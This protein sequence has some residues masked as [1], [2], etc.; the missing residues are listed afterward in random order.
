M[1]SNDSNETSVRTA[2]E[3]CSTEMMRDLRVICPSANL[4]VVAWDYAWDDP[5]CTGTTSLFTNGGHVNGV[6]IGTSI[7]KT[8]HDLKTSRHDVAGGKHQFTIVIELN[9]GVPHTGYDFWTSILLHEFYVHARVLAQVAQAIHNNG[10][11]ACL[12]PLGD[13]TG[14][15]HVWASLLEPVTFA[16][17]ADASHA[18]YAKTFLYP[19]PPKSS[20]KQFWTREFERARASEVAAF[21]R[22]TAH[23]CDSDGLQ[24]AV[25]L[26]ATKYRNAKTALPITPSFDN[27]MHNRIFGPN[28][29]PPS[30][31][32]ASK[33]KTNSPT[34]VMDT[35]S[36]SSRP[37]T[38]DAVRI[39]PKAHVPTFRSRA[40]D[41]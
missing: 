29:R 17:L 11:L 4:E 19:A 22:Q 30:P 5:H 35:L 12:T 36:L 20:G 6:E 15:R 33:R 23:G 37:P 28:E 27:F 39:K 1:A 34:T 26:N 40:H 21:V 13:E 9:L 18:W 41:A 3:C 38:P 32:H 8:L 7:Y 14:I 24:E 2:I 10:F 25:I 31:P 16:D